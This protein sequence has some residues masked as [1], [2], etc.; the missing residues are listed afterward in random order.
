MKQA[1]KRRVLLAVAA[2]LLVL[3]VAGVLRY[4]NRPT[5]ILVATDIHYLSPSLNDHGACFEKTILNGDGKALAYIDE[6]TDAFVEQV[7]REKP[8]ALI[9]SGDLTLNGE[10]Q[11]HLD[12][13]QKLRSITDCGIPVLVLPANILG[14]AKASIAVAVTRKFVLLIPLIYLMPVL[15]PADKTMAVY[16]A[17]PVADVLAVT[18]TVILFSIQFRK[19]LQQINEPKKQA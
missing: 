10:K 4:Q 12:L 1:G 14:Y 3:V 6:L 5:K 18:F 17:E 7:I 16:R 11:S 19:A 13:A 8:A 15:F 2:L 9:L